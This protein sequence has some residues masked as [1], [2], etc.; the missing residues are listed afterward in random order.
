MYL[1]C[2][3]THHGRRLCHGDAAAGVGIESWFGGQGTKVLWIRDTRA[4]GLGREN[5]VGDVF[6]SIYG[7]LLLL[8][9]F[10][11]GNNKEHFIH[12]WAV[13]MRLLVQPLHSSRQVRY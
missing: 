10:L 3:S 5:G 13:G 6:I 12:R 4:S 9:L 1:P 8:F 2:F 11:I 7:L